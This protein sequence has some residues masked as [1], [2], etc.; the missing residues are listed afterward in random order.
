MLPHMETE[1]IHVSDAAQVT[2]L[3]LNMVT[4]LFNVQKF[5][6]TSEKAFFFINYK[7]SNLI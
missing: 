2:F 1:E 7:H 3:S 4:L 6:I 5:K